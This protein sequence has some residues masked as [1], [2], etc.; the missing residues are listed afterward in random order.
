[1]T[2][3]LRNLIKVHS[4]H[5]VCSDQ[6]SLGELLGYLRLTADDLQLNFDQAHHQAKAFI[7]LHDMTPFC[8]CI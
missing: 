2:S 4:N 5:S 8:P 1:M 6:E 3:E 7:E